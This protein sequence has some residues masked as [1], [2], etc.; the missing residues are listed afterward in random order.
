[1]IAFFPFLL[2]RIA[3]E[4]KRS[5]R[6]VLHEPSSRTRDLTAKLFGGFFFA[7]RGGVE[8]SLHD[9]AFALCNVPWP[10]HKKAFVLCDAPPSD[11]THPVGP[12]FTI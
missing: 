9:E 8:Q 1:M 11:A 10:L 7:C 12:W 6:K 5:R 4:Q 2:S 3:A